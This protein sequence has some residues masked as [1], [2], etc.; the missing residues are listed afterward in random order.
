MSQKTEFKIGDILC[1]YS[2]EDEDV[3]T[4]GCIEDITNRGKNYVV[5][6]VDDP[7][8]ITF[9]YQ[10][11]TITVFHKVLMDETDGPQN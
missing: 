10:Y 3:P 8:D 5:H 4:L 6:W 2:G 1:C 7:E 9:N 11:Q